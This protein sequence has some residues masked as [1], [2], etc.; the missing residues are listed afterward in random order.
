MQTFYLVQQ[1]FLYILR[2]NEVLFLRH[3]L[4]WLRL[5]FLYSNP[6]AQISLVLELQTC[7]TFTD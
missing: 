1:F 4:E 7:D 5:A 6:S 3:G 2:I